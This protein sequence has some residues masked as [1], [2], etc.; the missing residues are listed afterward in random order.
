MTVSLLN[1]GEDIRREQ[2]HVALCQSEGLWRTS[3]DRHFSR[4]FFLWFRGGCGGAHKVLSA[5]VMQF[6]ASDD[7][8]GYEGYK[9]L[10]NADARCHVAHF[11]GGFR[12]QRRE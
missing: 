6:V 10:P 5:S 3:H 12:A 1:R 8:G 7:G 9:V 2:T 4:I 11:Y